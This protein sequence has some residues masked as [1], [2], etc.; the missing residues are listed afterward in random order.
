MKAIR[1]ISIAILSIALLSCIFA[2]F[3]APNHYAKQDREASNEPPSHR[4]LLGTDELGRDRFARLVYGSRVS[5]TLAPAAAIFSVLLAEIIGGLAGYVGGVWKSAAMAVTDLVLSMPWLFLLITVRAALPLNVSPMVSVVVTFLL[6]GMLG[7]A[8]SARMLCSAGTQIRQ[9]G[10][11]LQ[12]Q[13]AGCRGWRLF[14][15]HVAPN[16]K[17]LL[18]AQFWISVPIFILAE[19][20]LGLLGLGISEPLPSWGGMLRELENYSALRSEPW[21]FAALILLFLVVSAFQFVLPENAANEVR[22]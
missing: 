13:A 6:L 14:F 21:R 22:S 17:P 12:A 10:Y 4:Y 15:V 9:S 7:W 5:F 19:A 18:L 11:V 1:A 8:A 3:V 16:L 20:N 2:E